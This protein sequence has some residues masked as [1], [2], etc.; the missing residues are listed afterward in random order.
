MHSI[1]MVFGPTRVPTKKM[2]HKTNWDFITSHWRVGRNILQLNWLP[3]I[4]DGKW[5]RWLQFGWF[6]CMSKRSNRSRIIIPG[7]FYR[8]WPIYIFLAAQSNSS[9]PVDS[10]FFGHDGLSADKM[11]YFRMHCMLSWVC[12]L[13][14]ATQ[15][16]STLFRMHKLMFTIR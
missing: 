13:S 8:L 11:I 2:K 15:M 4:V 5:F 7:R 12:T 14:V 1:D 10:S 9:F 16:H 3:M 6:D